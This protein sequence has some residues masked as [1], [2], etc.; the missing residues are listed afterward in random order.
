MK[1]LTVITPTGIPQVIEVSPERQLPTSF[2]KKKAM[3]IKT[4]FAFRESFKAELK[5]RKVSL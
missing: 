5:R 4:P 2:L 1:A 3:D